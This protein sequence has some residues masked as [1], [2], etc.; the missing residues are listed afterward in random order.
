M[1]CAGCQGFIGPFPSAFLDKKFV[2]TAAK[3]GILGMV[4]EIFLG[5]RSWELGVRRGDEERRR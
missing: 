4:D 3:V 5:V 1:V 2:R